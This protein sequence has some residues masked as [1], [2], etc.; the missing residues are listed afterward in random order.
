MKTLAH[1]LLIALSFSAVTA[2]TS[3]QASAGVPKQPQHPAAYQ[4]S[5][6]GSADGTKLNVAVD[7]QT[8]GRVSVRLVDTKGAVLFEHAIS[9]SQEKYRGRLVIGDLPS[10]M[11]QLEI[12]NGA[13]TT[14]RTV[15]ISTV[16]PVSETRSIAL[17]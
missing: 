11:Y 10:G 8:G 6:Y 17:L 3:V 7:K 16:V 5:I 14:I 15:Q 9:N 4:T 1:N 2:F 13:E 12:S